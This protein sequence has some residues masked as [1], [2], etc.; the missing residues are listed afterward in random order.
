MRAFYGRYRSEY[1]A[2]LEEITLKKLLIVPVILFVILNLSF[3]DSPPSSS[4]FAVPADTLKGSDDSDVLRG[5]DGNDFI[6]AGMGDD[7]LWGEAGD[8]HLKGGEGDDH[9]Y[10]GSESDVMEGGDGV[11]A[12]AEVPLGEVTNLGG[13][14]DF[15]VTTEQLQ[16]DAISVTEARE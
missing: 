13:D 8:D 1:D 3:S 15:E 7:Q 11:G 14:R 12:R 10:G 5:D 2:I 4:R 9:L 6:E 16:A